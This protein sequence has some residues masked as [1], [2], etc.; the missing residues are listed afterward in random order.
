MTVPFVH[1]IADDMESMMYVVLYCGLRWLPH[2]VPEVSVESRWMNTFFFAGKIN[3]DGLVDGADAKQINR[4]NR[5]YTDTLRGR[6]ECAAFWKW[7]TTVM[8]YNSP[9]PGD[10]KYEKLRKMWNG[11]RPLYKFWERFLEKYKGALPERDRV[12][13]KS[14]LAPAS[15]FSTPHHATTASS[16]MTFVQNGGG[17]VDSTLIFP[18]IQ[19]L[20]PDFDI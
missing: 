16:G 11:P 9:L 1:S 4:T 6:F 18:R 7:M 10:S 19:R 20:P 13:R 12:E 3:A 8:D 14:V 15:V 17:M 5:Q 2:S